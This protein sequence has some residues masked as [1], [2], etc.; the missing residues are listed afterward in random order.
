M[1][2]G[3]GSIGTREHAGVGERHQ[4]DGAAAD[5]HRGD[6]SVADPRDNESGQTLWKRTQDRDVI[7]RRELQQSNDCGRTDHRNQNVRHAFAAP[8]KQDHCQRACPEHKS[9][10]VRLSLQYRGGDRP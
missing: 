7:T 9:R 3:P 10:P 4:G 6:I 2:A 1:S 8:E 5:Q